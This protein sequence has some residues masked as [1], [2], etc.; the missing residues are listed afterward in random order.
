M[1]EA[2]VEFANGT[3]ITDEFSDKDDF[4]LW[5]KIAIADF[6]NIVYIKIL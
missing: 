6:G 4:N 3:A 1:F 5:V 2:T